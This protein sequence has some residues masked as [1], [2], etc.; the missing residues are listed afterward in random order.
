DSTVVADYE[1][2]GDDALSV[3]LGCSE[4]TPLEEIV[5]DL[6]AVG[7][8]AEWM[9]IRPCDPRLDDL[10]A[11]VRLAEKVADLA[12]LLANPPSSPTGPTIAVTLEAMHAAASAVQPPTPAATRVIRAIEMAN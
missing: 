9:P 3:T 2:I 1:P 10:Q 5:E 4:R 7:V 8:H 12:D 6:Q 11:P